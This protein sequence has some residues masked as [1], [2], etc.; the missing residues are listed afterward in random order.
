MS[1]ISKAG[2]APLPTL[3]TGKAGGTKGVGDVYAGGGVV[4]S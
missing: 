1:S 4:I 3:K 2:Q